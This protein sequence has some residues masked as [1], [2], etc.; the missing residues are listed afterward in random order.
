M[1]AQGRG[2]LPARHVK[3]LL[4]LNGEEF[5]YGAYVTLFRRLPDSDG[6]VNYLTELQFGISKLDIVS[7]LR[8]SSEGRK[9]THSLSGYRSFVVKERL[10]SLLRI[11]VSGA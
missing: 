9:F 8:Q 5:V 4:E 6:L 2:W 7:R 3:E 11:A 10:R 1:D